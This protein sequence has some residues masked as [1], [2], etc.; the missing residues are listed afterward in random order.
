MPMLLIIVCSI[1]FA[2]N[3]FNYRILI[4]NNYQN[5]KKDFITISNVKWD[6]HLDEG[7]N[8]YDASIQGVRHSDRKTL[9]FRWKGGITNKVDELLYEGYTVPIWSSPILREDHIIVRDSDEFPI[10]EIYKAIYVS[11]VFQLIITAILVYL[12]RRFYRNIKQQKK[13][14]LIKPSVYTLCFFI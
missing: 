1:W 14:D 6:L 7:T 12:I 8:T 5:F 9:H 4:V 2:H 13:L 3:L 11:I 10:D